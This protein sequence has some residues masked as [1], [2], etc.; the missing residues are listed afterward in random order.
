MKEA[1]NPLPERRGSRPRTTSTNPHVQLEQNAAAEHWAELVQRA[2]MLPDVEERPSLVSVPGA[3][4]LWLR[5]GVPAGPRDAFMVGREFAHIHPLPE[6]SMHVALPPELA[7]VAVEKG[8][9]EPHPV[10]RMGYIPE[11]IVMIYGPRDAEEVEV[12]WMLLRASY[13]YALGGDRNA[14]S[15]VHG[16]T[17]L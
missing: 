3:R 14:A 4:A 6:G 17:H 13:A 8:W 1:A 15:R 10:A 7:R 2:F 5:D 11:T 9:A 12:G 16:A